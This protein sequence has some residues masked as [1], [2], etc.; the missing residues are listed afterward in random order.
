MV[1]NVTTLVRVDTGDAIP[2]YGFSLSLDV[3]SWAWGFSADLN[4][5]ALPLLEPAAP[6]EPVVLEATVNGLAFRV[7]PRSIGHQRAGVDEPTLRVDGVGHTA[8]LAEPFSPVTAFASAS[9]LTLQQLLDAAMPFG[10]AVDWGVTAWPV[11]GGVWSHQGTPATAAQAIAAAAGGYVLPHPNLQRIAVV[12][13]YPVA[14]WS[15]ATATPDIELPAA[16]VINEGTEWLD[17]PRYNGVYVSGM[18]PGGVQRLVR[19]LGTAADL[20]AP[21]V[22]DRLTTHQDAALQR[23]LAVLGYTGSKALLMLGLPVLPATGVIQPGKLVRYMNGAVAQQGLVRGV[24]IDVSAGSAGQPVEVWQTIR[25]E[26]Q[27]S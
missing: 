18:G 2:C 23:G 21:M 7:I 24:R 4:A 1:T 6:G 27:V 17:L 9:A 26:T 19:R 3:D 22:A 14:P 12:P 13:R 16:V 10:W 20:L 8:V 15:W 5:S 25:L 11:P